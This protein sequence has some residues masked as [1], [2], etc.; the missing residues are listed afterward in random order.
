MRADY[1][2]HT[3]FSDDSDYP[4]E[5]VVRD[6]IA[7][8]LEELCFTDHVDFDGVGLPPADIAARNAEIE[9]LKGQFPDIDISF[10][11]E[12]GMK[13]KA[14]YEDA[15]SHVKDCH[16]DFVIGSVHI[17]NGVDAYYP[18]YFQ[19]RSREEA[20]L[21][22]IEK[23]LECIRVS[24]FSVMGHYDFC[25]KHSPYAER[26][27]SYSLAPQIFDEI[28]REL[29]SRGKA[30]EVNTSAWRNDAPWG[31]DI[32]RRYRELGG[33]YVTTGSDA[34]KPER[35]GNRLSEALDMIRAAGIPYVATF[36]NMEPI[37]H[38][39]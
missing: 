39:I 35:V 33:E 6:A 12:F 7:L 29:I 24:D 36:K 25:A 31:L 22:Y 18:E 23:D 2:V 15:Y 13:D 34:H 1:H 38:R 28:F 10:G 19:G 9:A 3:A 26:S 16:M 4:M 20:Y 21:A 17:V 30:F 8:G 11:M 5:Q 37:M 14:A 32:L 27:M